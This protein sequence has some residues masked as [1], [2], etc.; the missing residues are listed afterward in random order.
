MHWKDSY[1]AALI[2][3]DPDR[4]LHLIHEAE[5]AISQQSNGSPAPT[6]QER[7]ELGDAISTLRLLKDNVCTPSARSER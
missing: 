4:L 2:E 6:I 7:Q 3:V 5:V 1:R